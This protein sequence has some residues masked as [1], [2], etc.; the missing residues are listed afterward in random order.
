MTVKQTKTIEF[1]TKTLNIEYNG[2]TDYD[3]WNFIKTH[4]NDA[5]SKRV[6]RSRAWQMDDDMADA[7]GLDISMFC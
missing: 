5:K 1:I 3:A 4:L 2:K 7:Y 6:A